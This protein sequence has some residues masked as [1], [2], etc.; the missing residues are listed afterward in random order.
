MPWVC[1]GTWARLRQPSTSTAR[2]TVRTCM[3]NSPPT[4]ALYVSLDRYECYPK[5]LCLV[6][7]VW[8][9]PQ[10]ICLVRQVRML[11][12]L[13]CLVRQ[14]WMSP[15]PPLSYQPGTN[16]TLTP[17]SCKTGNNVRRYEWHPNP[18]VLL[19]RNGCHPNPLCLVRQ[20]QLSPQPLLSYQTGA[21]GR[22]NLVIVCYSSAR[23]YLILY[24]TIG[25]V[26][27]VAGSR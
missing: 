27:C 7:E 20:I 19:D 15:Q 4:P 22:P 26:V 8:M 25:S 17:L 18:S 14:I 5:P 6:R 21:N 23:H 3:V 9:L 1:W 24:D 11:P 16:V 2:R 13:L 12:Q 10:P